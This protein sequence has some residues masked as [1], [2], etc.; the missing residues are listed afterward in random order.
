MKN[1]LTI[2]LLSF[3][4]VG[5]VGQESNSNFSNAKSASKE[6]VSIVL[7]EYFKNGISGLIGISKECYESMDLNNTGCVAIDVAAHVWDFNMANFLKFP[8]EE[9]FSVDNINSRAE[10][11]FRS[12]GVKVVLKDYMEDLMRESYARIPIEWENQKHNFE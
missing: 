7:A 5:C 4:V 9:Y 1:L 3:L 12:K 6:A 10:D 2:G 8:K 11:Y